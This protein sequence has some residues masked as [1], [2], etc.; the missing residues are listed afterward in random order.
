MTAVEPT[1]RRAWFALVPLLIGTFTGT[2]NNSVVNVPMTEILADF[3]VSLA[4][5]ALVVVAFV[6]AFAVLMPLS[7]WLGDRLGHRQVFCAA[8][9]LLA[10][11]AAGAALAPS[12]PLLVAFRALQGAATA[13]VLPGVMVLIAAMFGP[14]SRGRALG[15]W[16][17]VNGAGQAAGPALGGLLADWVGWRAIFWPTIPLALLALVMALRLVPRG[18]ARPIPLEW[19]GALLLT[20]SAALCLGSA[21]LVG[22]LGLSSVAVWITAAGG[23]CAGMGFVRVESGRRDAFL[24]P[25]LLLEPRYL[26]SSIA[27]LT[28]MFCLGATLLGVPLYVTQRHGVATAT[29]GLLVLAMPLAMAA[30]APLAGLATERL[31]PRIALRTGLVALV[32]GQVVL[33]VQLGI[34]RPPD[35]LVIVNLAVV[36]AGVA[37]VQTP[38]AA[39]STRSRAGQRGSGL[40][41]FNLLRFGGSALGASWVGAVAGPDSSYGLVFGVCTGIAVLGLVGSFAGRDT[42]V[43][44]KAGEAEAPSAEAAAFR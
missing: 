27:V 17:G 21:S 40:G 25:G 38:A 14:G 5:G 10:V 29:A 42:A 36:G 35:V 2:V 30:L 20:L 13:A 22:P 43:V 28:Q 33:T 23:V 32:L 26:R 16:A 11:G 1:S 3:D 7:G 34:G 6:L 4:Y 39:G 19:R 31:T 41:L 8:M 9:V 12:L 18:S 44:S 15:F 24:P 37:F